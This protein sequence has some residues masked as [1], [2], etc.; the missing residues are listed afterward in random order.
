MAKL[1]PLG[2]HLWSKRF[3]DAEFQGAYDV[4]NDSLGNVVIAGDFLGQ[5]DFGGDLLTSAGS[6]DAFVV[7]L[8]AEGGHVWS[9]RFGDAS[10]QSTTRLAVDGSNNIVAVGRFTGTIDLGNGS[11]NS[12][13][14][15][16]F[17]AKFDS[18]GTSL[19][20]KAFAV[21][22]MGVAADQV[23]NVFVSGYF[24]G[25]VDFGGGLLT[26][27]GAADMFIA[28]FDAAGNH[29]WS[30]RFG[31]VKD[32]NATRVVVDAKG[33]ISVVGEFDG[34]VDLGGGPLVSDAPWD[35]LLAQFDEFGNFV[36]AKKFGASGFQAARGLAVDSSGNIIISAFTDA[37]IDFGHGSLP[38][39]GSNDVYIA[40]FSSD[41]AH[42]WSATLGDSSEQYAMSVA[43]D[44]HGNVLLI[45]GFRSTIDFGLGSLA[46]TGG[47]DIFVAKFLP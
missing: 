10:A 43:T 23:G 27:A 7:K 5:V 25:S 9:K 42:T 20:S 17:I 31:D 39:Q 13:D 36:W 38:T 45:G 29:V 19:W 18:N 8:N 30:K 3:G 28:K 44:S 37:P 22:V 46:S 1:D 4:I 2:S 6:A 26:S 11:F 16:S 33:R 32:Q 41:G 15:S 21:G 12:A 47:Y 35:T 40:K 34:R 14:S 24:Q